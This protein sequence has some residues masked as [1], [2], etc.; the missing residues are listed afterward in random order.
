MRHDETIRARRFERLSRLH[1]FEVA[2]REID[3]RGWTVVN[4]ENHA[5]GEVRD[6][7]VDTERMT[8]RFLDVELEP[9][10]FHVREE[11]ARI[12]VPIT[13]ADRVGDQRRLRVD[14]L[15]HDTVTAMAA[16]RDEH[17]L[18]FWQGWWDA[19]AAGRA[20]DDSD[21]AAAHRTTPTD[22]RHALE[23]VPPGGTVRIP[24][25][26]EEL[27]VERRPLHPDEHVVARE[28]DAGP[29]PRRDDDLR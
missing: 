2:R 13:R 6:L 23:D 5:V 20:R 11:D 9:K 28:H 25:V 1:D 16:A 3:P 12:L 29:V 7:I 21:V 22:L 24:I 8:G 14:G 4:A 10:V 15:T 27:V 19:T 26:N 17:Y 18:S